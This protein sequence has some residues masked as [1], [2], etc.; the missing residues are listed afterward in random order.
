M[1]LN[2]R[3]YHRPKTLAEALALLRRPD[4]RTVPIGGG[5]QILAEAAR[6]VEAV[7]DL[8]D[9]GLDFIRL[10]GNTLRIG[11]TTPLQALVE[12][13]ES[14]AYGGGI[15]AEAA[16]ETAPLPLRN[17][18]TVGGA[19]VGASGEQPLATVLIAL[20]AELV[21][22]TEPESPRALRLE[23]FYDYR[24]ALRRQG[25]IAT[26]IR[27]PI[28][29]APTGASFH[30][31]ARTP[32]DAPIV[33]VAVRLFRGVDEA[34]YGVRIA[35]GGVA[36]RPV[37]L[38]EVEHTLEGQPPNPE[39]FRAAARQA[40][41]QVNPP[42]DFRGSPEYRREMVEVLLQRALVDAARRAGFAW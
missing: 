14:T 13:P 8:Q 15:L 2:L 29:A 12:A 16:R 6:E 1:L 33:G 4:I 42:G 30:K 26:E 5:T 41:E 20:E 40:R 27:L 10:E 34:C 23:A 37:R 7:V 31:V 19:V 38:R 17:Q 24:E 36:P 28:S 18:R 25:M 9:L 21:V 32:A 39:R 22:F 3:E 35:V 11:A